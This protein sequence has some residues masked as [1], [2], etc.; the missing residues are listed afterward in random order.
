VTQSGPN[1]RAS[2]VL[3]RARSSRQRLRSPNLAN[4]VKFAYIVCMLWRS[5]RGR[6]LNAPAA[7]FIPANQSSPSTRQVGLV[8][9]TRP[10]PV[11]RFSILCKK[12]PITQTVSDSIPFGESCRGTNT[13]K[14]IARC[15]NAAVCQRP[16]RLQW[17]R[18]IERHRAQ[19]RHSYARESSPHVRA[20]GGRLSRMPLSQSGK[21][22]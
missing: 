22:L 10:V 20:I 2:R 4:H 11:L 13:E 3:T 19:S 15:D 18:T 6:P 14:F 7:T 16:V 21:R 12:N 5:S 17:G 9:R 8:G 1:N